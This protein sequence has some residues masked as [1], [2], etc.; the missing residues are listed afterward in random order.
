MSRGPDQ[1][2]LSPDERA[3]LVAFV[4]GELSE[5]TSRALSTKL[6]QSATARRE[7][8][9]LRKTWELLGHLPFPPVDPK[10]SERTITEIRRLDLKNPA[11]ESSIQTWSS[12]AGLAGI[13][14]ALA[15][16]A[17]G[18]A[19]GATR[20]L[21]PDASARL[22]RDLSMAEHLD[23]YLEVGSFEFLDELVEAPEFNPVTH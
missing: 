14:L 15:V 2:R 1:L 16:L 19:Y 22:A 17:S 4:D 9:M 23:E 12:W 5:A 7:V 10:F 18:L 11:W 20:W 13:Y 6:T 21:W 3:D 8:E